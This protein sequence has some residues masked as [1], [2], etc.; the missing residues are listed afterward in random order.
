[1]IKYFEV[2]SIFLLGLFSIL[3]ISCNNNDDDLDLDASCEDVICT[4][5][6]RRMTVTVQDEIEN[7]VALDSFEVVN[8]KDGSNITIAVSPSEFEGAREFGQYPLIED[9]ILGKNQ[10]EQIQFRGFIDGQEVV[11]SDY[12][13]STDCCHIGLVLGSLLL[14]L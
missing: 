10:V 3:L 8:L 11:T 6:L 1:M 13:V 14:T 5:E 2:T 7:P 9:G 4:L 12:E